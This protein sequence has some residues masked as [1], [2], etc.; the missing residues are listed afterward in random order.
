MQPYEAVYLE[1]VASAAF[2]YNPMLETIYQT[3]GNELFKILLNDVFGEMFTQA[4]R[5]TFLAE[6]N[7]RF[8][9]FIRSGWCTGNW[10]SWHSCSNEEY[11]D[12]VKQQIMDLSIEQRWKWV[13]RICEVHDLDVSH[14]HV[15]PVAVLPMFQ[16]KG[17]GTKLLM[18]YFSR[19]G[20]GVSF[21]ET[22]QEVNARFYMR[23][24]YRFVATD[25]VLGQKGY[26]LKRP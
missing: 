17:V 11:D 21:L 23:L 19:L 26:W 14:S 15:G 7:G 1:Y 22:F 3:T 24:G 16:G 12:I 13:E 18:D 9:G 20:D 6:L 5:D 4:P 25:S 8:I 2:Q 10:H